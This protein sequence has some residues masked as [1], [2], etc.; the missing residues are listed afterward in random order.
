[1]RIAT[2]NLNRA[3]PGRGKRTSALLDHMAD[4]RA[5][6][7]IL[8]ETFRG[9]QPRGDYS[10]IASSSN[11]PDRESAAGE[12]WV[13][14][15][16]RVPATLVP[17]AADPERTAAARLEP[18]DGAPLLLVGTVLPWLSDDQYAPLR[19]ADAFCEVLGRQA[20]EWRSL[21][22]DHPDAGLCVAGDFNQDLASTHYYG[23]AKGRVALQ[24]A[25]ADASLACLT[26]GS[27][28][29][30]A[31]VPDH[32]SI[33]H[34]CVSES[35]LANGNPEVGSWPTPPLAR[36]QLTDHYG[37]HATLVAARPSITK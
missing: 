11:A 29:P 7:W 2:W 6:V 15:W 8:T 5:D 23:S 26:A 19:G 16:S 22:R 35:M 4:V 1:V 3:R 37:V 32:A 33:D 20:A 34:L 27:R 17:L 30:L 12:C 24:Q 21:Q 25:L 14:I 18:V 31:R 13:A 9:L 10:L 36:G 28:D